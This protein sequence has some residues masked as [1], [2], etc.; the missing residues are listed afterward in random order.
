VSAPVWLVIAARKSATKVSSSSHTVKNRGN[1]MSAMCSGSTPVRSG[2]SMRKSAAS[3]NRSCF[4][5][6]IADHQRGI[7]ADVG[8]DRPQ[9]G[10]VVAF[11]AEAAAR[12]GQDVGAGLGGVAGSCGR[13]TRKV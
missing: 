9:D 8:R 6:E 10:A 3:A 13:H 12:R 7:H 5:A 2:G 4:A 11:G 1:R